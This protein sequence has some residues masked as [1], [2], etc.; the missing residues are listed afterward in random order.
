[1]PLLHIGTTTDVGMLSLLAAAAI[2]VAVLAIVFMV[3]LVLMQFPL[4]LVSP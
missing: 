2:V 4:M 3:L 1:M